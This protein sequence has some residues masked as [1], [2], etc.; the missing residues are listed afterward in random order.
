MPSKVARLS[1]VHTEI[2]YCT[3]CSLHEGRTRTVPGAGDPD[4]EI[5]FIGEA[6]GKN[7][8][9]QGLPFV[10]RSGKYLDELLKGIGLSREQVFIANVVK[11]RPP[12]NRDPQ[13]NEIETCN[14]Y[15]RQQ[16][17]I[18][19]PLVIATLGRF[20]MNMFFPNAKISRIHGIP[21]YGTRRAYFPFFHPAAALRDPSKRDDMVSDFARLLEVVAEMRQ[22]RANPD[23]VIDEEPQTSPEEESPEA[24][25]EEAPDEDAPKQMGLF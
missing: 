22:R 10:G 1:A 3:Q 11:C 5:M 4:A 14:P 19:D 18:I 23:P 24:E 17:E 2:F 25:T 13:P 6:P 16:I 20:S 12:E 15:I 7:E 9:E 8:D 21:E